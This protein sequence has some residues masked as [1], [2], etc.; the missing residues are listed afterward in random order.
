MSQALQELELLFETHGADHLDRRIRGD[1]CDNGCFWSAVDA[2]HQ[3]F[4]RS[5]I[6]VLGCIEERL[7]E[8]AAVLLNDMS[9]PVE[10]RAGWFWRRPNERSRNP[11]LKPVD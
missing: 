7:G 5:P 3:C 4:G 10:R 2:V 6:T 11:G 8:L 9:S 1:V